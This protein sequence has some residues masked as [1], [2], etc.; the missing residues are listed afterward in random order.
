MP[1]SA[2][3]RVLTDFSTVSKP[4]KKKTERKKAAAQKPS[5]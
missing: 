3:L 1:F 2:A 4:Q 5:I